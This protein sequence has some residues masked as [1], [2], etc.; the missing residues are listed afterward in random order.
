M[1]SWE[2]YRDQVRTSA[3]QIK[4]CE[5]VFHFK[6]RMYANNEEKPLVH[7]ICLQ[8]TMST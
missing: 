3:Q 7:K 5:F 1:E 8:L 6:Q 2:F 4:T